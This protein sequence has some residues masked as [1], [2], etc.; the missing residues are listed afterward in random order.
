MNCRK[1]LLILCCLAPTGL[2]AQDLVLYNGGVGIGEREEAPKD[3]V[4]LEFFAENGAFVAM[5]DVTVKDSAGEVLVDTVTDGPW[6]ILD[7][8]QGQYTVH[9]ELEDDAES[10]FIDVN[11]GNEKFG[12]EFDV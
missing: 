3:G 12:Y 11:T 10:T 2:P 4:K 9:A 1:F 7:L 5:V 8:P 6:L